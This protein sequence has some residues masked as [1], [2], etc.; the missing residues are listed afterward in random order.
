V[1]LTDPRDDE[2]APAGG[3]PHPANVELTADDLAEIK[4]AAAGIWIEGDRY[5]E[6]LERMMNL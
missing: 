3:E 4:R 5:P 2:A 6:A 1:D